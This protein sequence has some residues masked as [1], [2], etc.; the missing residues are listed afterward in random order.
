MD[1]NSLDSPSL[2]VVASS[3]VRRVGL[4]EAKR[5]LE[6]RVSGV[7][8]DGGRLVLCRGLAITHS[9][10]YD[11]TYGVQQRGCSR[12]HHPGIRR[13]YPSLGLDR[14][15]VDIVSVC[16]CGGRDGRHTGREARDDLS[17]DGDGLVV[18]AALIVVLVYDL[19]ALIIVE[20]CR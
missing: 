1:V 2:S 15:L 12:R 10:S 11:E 13:P 18:L 16:A 9:C 5:I 3:K 6:R 19:L 8:D 14:T 4:R 7:E 20:G 17:I